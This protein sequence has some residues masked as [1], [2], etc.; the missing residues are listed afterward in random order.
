M[1]KPMGDII[2]SRPTGPVYD[3][4][5]N[6][7]VTPENW[8]PD[9][10]ICEIAFPELRGEDNHPE[11]W[12]VIGFI[13][14]LWA[15]R[16]IVQD[17]KIGI[18]AD[19]C[20][21]DGLAVGR[22]PH[23]RAV[24]GYV[25]ARVE[26]LE[27]EGFK[28]RVIT[29][30]NLAVSIIGNIARH[31]LDPMIL[32]D[33]NSRI[34]LRTG[35]KLYEFMRSLNGGRTEGLDDGS[36]SFN[37]ES[38]CSIDLTTATDTPHRRGI[39]TL[40]N[41]IMEGIDNHVPSFHFLRLA[42]DLAILPREFSLPGG[43][44]I[45][46]LEHRCG[47]MMGESLSGIFLNSLS[48]IIRGI[49][50]PF[51]LA[52]LDMYHGS[53]A[54]EADSFI[55]G[56]FEIIQIILDECARD[57][58]YG[59]T[60]SQSGDDVVDFSELPKGELSRW[61][62]LL[63]R[64]FGFVPS[65]NT[66]YDSDRFATFT[67]EMAVNLPNSGGWTFVDTTKPRLFQPGVSTESVI[68]HISQ[69]GYTCKFASE[70]RILSTSEVV[71]SMISS[72]RVLRDRIKRYQL[73]IGLPPTLGGIN[74]PDGHLVDYVPGLP[75]EDQRMISYLAD[76]SEE[77]FLSVKFDHLLDNVKDVSGTR[78]L[79]RDLYRTITSL[80]DIPGYPT[81]PDGPFGKY[82][83]T[84]LLIRGAMPFTLYNSLLNDLKIQFGLLS[85]QDFLGKVVRSI[86]S[87]GA[88]NLEATQT[89]N[90]LIK[91]RNRRQKLLSMIPVEY[92]AKGVSKSTAAYVARRFQFFEDILIYPEQMESLVELDG[93]PSFSIT[94]T[95][96]SGG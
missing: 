79:L 17:Q 95:L 12:G 2:P 9:R 1:Q 90:S 81:G 8:D 78:E 48:C 73:P 66:F 3:I 28:C 42:V 7:F 83:S 91:L 32:D 67:E 75:A 58:S 45:D 26:P 55:S 23:L 62:V 36:P 47:L 86:E 6:V 71:D 10:L 20:E 80:E 51:R 21:Y 25:K 88:I 38:V 11:G 87:L 24:S 43:Q 39:T 70:E 61:Y 77:Q 84:S 31:L 37:F 57:F 19:S 40:L 52:L 35:V 89:V 64:C 18:Y 16:T 74:H 49:V 54:E 76:C 22:V 5:G 34:G 92:V 50:R 33:P 46:H 65:E 94:F 4:T 53:S 29:I 41:G 59:Q 69:I 56:C 15:V 85:L 60:S 82:R 30:T 27:E 96:S 14:L 93:Y 13:G 68:S 44:I 63:Y 72:N